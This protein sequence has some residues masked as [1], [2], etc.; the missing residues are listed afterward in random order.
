MS[1]ACLV[2][3][4]LE[5][6]IAENRGNDH[7]WFFVH[8]PKTAGSSFRRELA[9]TLRPNY[10]VHVDRDPQSE[11]RRQS[12]EGATQ[13][14]NLRLK[15]RTFRFASGHIP[16]SLLKAHV[17][18]WHEFK[19]ITMLREPAL[20]AVSDY[21]YQTTPAH[22]P[23]RQFIERFPTFEKYLEAPRMRN[24]MFNFLRPSNNATVEECI[25]F[26]VERFAFVG[27]VE[28]YP[29]SVRLVTRLMEQERSP[30]LYVRKTEDNDY[31][32]FEVTPELLNRVREINGLD[33][34]LYD[35]FYDKL[36]RIRDQV[37]SEAVDPTERVGC[38]GQPH[39]SRS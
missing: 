11:P 38:S 1:L 39:S 34:I 6:Y 14:F 16:I 15:E 8:I 17:D 10:N 23:H 30:T 35:Y 19:L 9:N 24:R 27:L 22:P 5:G 36:S 33:V 29:L 18:T 25:E 13:E 3:A 4:D 2:D 21:R 28:M 20:R 26:I 31:N 7:C 12:I 37:F 32:Q